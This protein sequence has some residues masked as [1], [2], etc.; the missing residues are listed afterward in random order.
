MSCT[1]LPKDHF[2]ILVDK[3]TEDK[4]VGFSNNRKV[5][6]SS[7][8]AIIIFKYQQIQTVELEFLTMDGV[9]MFITCTYN[10]QINPEK[11]SELVSIIENYNGGIEARIGNLLNAELRAWSRSVLGGLTKS[12]IS[13]EM[14]EK[15]L[16]NK[17]FNPNFDLIKLTGIERLEIK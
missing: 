7:K 9:A 1:S 15:H 14:V 10:C 3:Q 8:E 12:D 5:I 16:L 13:K 11:I 6:V 17:P 4:I 2:G